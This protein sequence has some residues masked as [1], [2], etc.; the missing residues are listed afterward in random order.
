[1]NIGIF[2]GSFDPIHIGHI[3]LANYIVEFTEIDKIWFLVSP[4]SPF[5]AD[6]E[7]TDENQRLEMVQQALADY[8][9]FE[10]SNI[11]FSL[12]KPSY[13]VNTLE[14][15]QEKYPEHQ[16]TL[17]IGAD[18]WASFE[19]WKNPERIL[20]RFKLMVYPRLGSRITIPTKM[21]NKVE[22][23]ES[24][25]IEISSTFI[26]EGISEGRDM[27]AFL[28][29]SVYNIINEKQLYK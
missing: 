17:I 12:P 11:E 21:R 27:K 16:F 5:K 6:K 9:H 23:L 19:D 20:D 4:Q 18:N 13:T 26:R 7:L 25:I 29:L 10:A 24:P 22:A 15:V 2:S 28:P 8:E 14:A 1:M 3:I